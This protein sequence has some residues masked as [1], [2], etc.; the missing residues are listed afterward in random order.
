MLKHQNMEKLGLARIERT[1]P[2]TGPPGCLDCNGTTPLVFH[3]KSV[4]IRN[5][6]KILDSVL[7][8]ANKEAIVR[9]F[10]RNRH[11]HG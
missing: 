8:E 7:D 4:K 3:L 1:G 10:F 5:A 9:L 6:Q 2:R 11:V